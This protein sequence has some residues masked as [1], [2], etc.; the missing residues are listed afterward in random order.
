MAKEELDSSELVD[1]VDVYQVIPGDGNDRTLGG[2][3]TPLITRLSCAIQDPSGREIEVGAMRSQT[4]THRVTFRHK[5]AI[6][7]SYR[8]KTS[9][10]LELKVEHVRLIRRK[11][12]IVYCSQIDQ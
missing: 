8:L 2:T 3:N 6:L 1:K 9:E 5:P 4:I 12:Q 10:G 11:K 7:T